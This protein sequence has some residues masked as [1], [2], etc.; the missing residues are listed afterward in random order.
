MKK[1]SPLKWH[2]REKD[3][4]EIKYSAVLMGVGICGIC[5]DVFTWKLSISYAKAVLTL[6]LWYLTCRCSLMLAWFMPFTAW[7]KTDREM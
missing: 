1:T 6:S 7:E 4:K 5:R 2:S 3:W